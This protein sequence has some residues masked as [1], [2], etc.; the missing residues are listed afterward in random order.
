M[1]ALKVSSGV[2]PIPFFFHQLFLR[3]L[4]ISLGELEVGIKA[5]HRPLC[6]PYSNYVSSDHATTMIFI[7]CSSVDLSKYG[8]NS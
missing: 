7:R 6:M 3:T 4:Y 1:R 8:N 5:R 2:P